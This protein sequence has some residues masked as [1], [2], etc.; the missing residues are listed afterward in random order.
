[1]RYRVTFD[2]IKL[3]FVKHFTCACGR[4]LRR[5]KTF[6]QTLNPWNMNE[7][8]SAKTSLDILIEI[9]ADARA[10]RRAPEPCVHAGEPDVNVP[11][12]P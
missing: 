8:G 12:T 5:Q 1:L 3:T 6:S 10:W 9:R 7:D 2:V 11:R 4:N